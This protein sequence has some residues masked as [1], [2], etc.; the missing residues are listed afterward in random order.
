MSGGFVVQKQDDGSESAGEDRPN[1]QA[2]SASDKT[3]SEAGETVKIISQKCRVM[4]QPQFV[5]AS[6]QT[7]K[8]G[9]LVTL[10]HRKGHWWYVE[11][12]NNKKGWLHKNHVHKKTIGL[13]S[14]ETG[15]GNT[16]DDDSMTGRA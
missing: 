8:R 2:S 3:D 7:L 1:V 11:T 10:L 13:R 6:V 5:C 12:F 15:S 16:H 14:G 4:V 9:H